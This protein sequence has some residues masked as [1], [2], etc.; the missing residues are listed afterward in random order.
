MPFWKKEKPKAP[1]APPPQAKP[2][3]A[4]KPAAEGTVKASPGTAAVTVAKP[5]GPGAAITPEAAI[6]EAHA[7]LVDLGLTTPATKAIFEKRVAAYSGGPEGFAKDYREEPHR[8]TTRV[9]VEW[10][11]VR[12]PIDFDPPG[13]LEEVNPRLSSFGL[14]AELRE[15]TWLDKELGLRK[16]RVLIG[17][18]EKIVRFKD[19]RDFVRGVNELIAPK[20]AVFLELETWSDEFAFLLARD[21]QWDRLAA[22]EAVVVKSPQTAVGGQCG[23][24]AAPVG[25][26]WHDC[27]TCGAVFEK[28]G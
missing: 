4:A 12:A 11:A 1:P 18:Q 23:E 3:P 6:R 16:G 9:L 28:G 21:P 13:F 25:K 15:L 27:L 5:P 26:Y 10:L 24:C 2:A 14:S 7:A 19:P 8:A 22:S 17:G 20:R